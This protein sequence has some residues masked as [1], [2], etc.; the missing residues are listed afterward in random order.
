MKPT[1]ITVPRFRPMHG[2]VNRILRVD[3]SNM[4]A[5]AEPS[6]PNLPDL[7]GARGLAHKLCWD[8]YPEPVPAFDPANPLMVVPGA[9]TGSTSPYS[10]RT[11]IL[12]FSPQTWPHEW[13][14]R[15][16]IGGHF[17][18]ELKRA[19]YDAL[20][21]TGSAESP[22]RIRIV[23]DQVSILPADDL[24]G[25]DAMDTLEALQGADGKGVRSLVI[26]PAGERLS[27]MATIQAGSSTAAGQGGFGGVMGSKK[28]K[29]VTVRGSGKVSLAHPERIR[30]LTRALRDEISKTPSKGPFIKEV[31]ASG[32]GR[33]RTVAC[34]EACPTPCVSEFID[35]PGV[36]QDRKWT[37]LWWCVGGGGFSISDEELDP[38]AS[39]TPGQAKF[40]MN[41]LTNR[42]GLNQFD[43]MGM[44][45]WLRESHDAGQLNE[46]E[47]VPVDWASPRFWAHLLRVIAD[48]EGIGD[49]LAEGTWRAARQTHVGGEFMR[50]RY[51]AW[52]MAEHW[53]SRTGPYWFPY[54]ITSAL[55][56]ACDTRDPF[57]AGHC[58]LWPLLG[59]WKSDDDTRAG[60][61]RAQMGLAER[62]YGTPDV[63]D[64]HSGYRGKAVAGHFHTLR[65]IIKDC[66]PSD[67]FAMFPLIWSDNTDDHFC[68]LQVDGLGEIEGPTA[69]WHIFAA[70]TGLE[71]SEKEFD[72]A[73]QRVATLERALQVRH[74]GR[75]RELDET[76][77]PHFELLEK[78]PSP[79][80]GERVGLDRDQFAP[81]L[82]EFYRLHGWDKN[83]QPTQEGLE[84]VGLGDI[85][86]P[87]VAGATRTKE[88]LASETDD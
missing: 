24:W 2:W 13:F 63:C 4:T 23:D 31:N 56:W 28:L 8:E 41:V 46:V 66:V 11:N 14:T 78:E 39:W 36:T 54:W 5:S 84:S 67:D 7:L 30:A 53:T 12:A 70:G 21:V 86:E 68:R 42:Y 64:P 85:Y 80:L 35:I 17:G 87:M 65:P 69:E 25:V 60:V 51:P 74:W 22:V 1:A 16:S 59:L 10:G 62:V 73:A 33:V 47:R 88:R 27:R 72:L 44:V 77:L 57:D 9:L 40:E 29:A 6:A 38:D 43:T 34:T 79:F 61:A 15:S 82:T 58:S 20:I 26:G 19:G 48:R 55:Q 32:R 45:R 83:G 52:G 81:V 3:L 76:V 18:G 75:D 50:P 49:A 37:S 71:W